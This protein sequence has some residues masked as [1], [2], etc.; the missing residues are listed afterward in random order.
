[1]PWIRLSSLFAIVLIAGLSGC[2][3]NSAVFE[4]RSPE[5]VWTVMVTVAQSP[6]YEDWTIM[7]NNVWVDPNYDRI[8]INRRL[9]RD[10]HHPEIE[11]VRQ[12]ETYDMQFVLERT[13]P[14]VVSGTIRN[15]V[16]PVKG[17][18][19]IR[20]FFDEMRDLLSPIANP[21]AVPRSDDEALEID[22]VNLGIVDLEPDSDEP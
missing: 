13:D 20:H 8:E 10:Y 14:P 7:E 16:I 2:T 9:K 12:I 5:Q 4:G 17:Q 21:P 6:E 11:P 1:M 18:E 22:E 3:T 19:M 15:P